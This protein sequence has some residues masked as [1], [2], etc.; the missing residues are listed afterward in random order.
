MDGANGIIVE[1]TIPENDNELENLTIGLN[2]S[3]AIN[4]LEKSNENLSRSDYIIAE[5][6]NELS[7]DIVTFEANEELPLKKLTVNIEP[8]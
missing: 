1:K 5:D 7:G 6:G 3:K 8:V 2:L 4:E